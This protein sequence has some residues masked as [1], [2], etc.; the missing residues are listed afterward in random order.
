VLKYKGRNSDPPTTDVTDIVLND[1]IDIVLN[2][3]IDIVLN[4]LIEVTD[5]VVK[6]SQTVT[7][8]VLNGITDRD[9]ESDIYSSLNMINVY[10]T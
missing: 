9:R 4:D 8:S 1:L 6:A 7:D 10:K 3:L 2:D 5:I